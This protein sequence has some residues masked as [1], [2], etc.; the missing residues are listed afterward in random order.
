VEVTDE[1]KFPGIEARKWPIKADNSR[2]ETI[3][4]LK[5]Q[6]FNI[7]AAQKWQ[8]SVEDGIARLRGFKQIIILAARNGERSAHYSYKTDRI[9]GEVCRY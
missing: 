8:G 2:P 5:G 6:G 9:T 1:A 3:S 4:Y 7:S